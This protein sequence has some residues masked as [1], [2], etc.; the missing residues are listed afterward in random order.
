MYKRTIDAVLASPPPQE[1]VMAKAQFGKAMYS[2][3][4]W[5]INTRV[6]ASGT[7]FVNVKYYAKDTRS[8][9]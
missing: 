5:A 1:V 4:A 2:R 6:D 3:I 8:T 7:Y 9:K